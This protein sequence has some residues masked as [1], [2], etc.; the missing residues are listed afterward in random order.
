MEPV[1]G[2][3]KFVLAGLVHGEAERHGCG[4]TGSTWVWSTSETTSPTARELNSFVMYLTFID[5]LQRIARRMQEHSH[6]L[7]SNMWHLSY[8]SDTH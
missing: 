8:I 4:S 2:D 3:H 1:S 5:F 7:C 6:Y